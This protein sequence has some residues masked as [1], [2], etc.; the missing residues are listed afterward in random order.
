MSLHFF[1][2]L[3]KQ[4]S[5]VADIQGFTI[6]MDNFSIHIEKT[7][8]QID[9]YVN[10]LYFPRYSPVYNR[11]RIPLNIASYYPESLTQPRIV[12]T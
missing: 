3:L 5:P 9:D 6:I 7:I 1:H 2:L 4:L 11:L 12:I 8:K 10:I